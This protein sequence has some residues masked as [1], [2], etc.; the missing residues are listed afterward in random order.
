MELVFA[1]NNKNKI[2]EIQSL[3]NGKFRILSLEE[4]G[5]SGEI[6]EDH[7][8]LEENAFQKAEFIQSRFAVNCF[9]DDTGLEIDALNGRPGVYSARYAGLKASAEDNIN[10][11]LTELGEETNR[12]AQFRTVISLLLNNQ[13][14]SFE[15]MVEGE[16]L[17]HKSGSDG[18]GYDPI[19]RPMGYEQ[20]F[21]EMSLNDKNEISHR[22]RAVQQLISF[23]EQ[24]KF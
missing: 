10:K 6:P 7:D 5:F 4:I 15:G 1:T 14:Y 3:L 21:A 12:R 17:M 8:T 9:A 20:S 18:F 22:G 19:F 24:V 23:L 16:I 11:V 2:K 13:R